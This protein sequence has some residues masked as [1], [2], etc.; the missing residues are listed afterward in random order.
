[1][2]EYDT[3]TAAAQQACRDLLLVWKP[4]PADGRFH[5]LEVEG[6]PHS[7]GGTI[8]LYADG[9]GGIATNFVT[10]EKQCFWSRSDSGLSPEELAA[11]K[12]RQ[13]QEME[14]AAQEQADRRKKAADTARAVMNSD[15]S[16][17]AALV[18]HDY[19]THKQAGATGTMRVIP[20]EALVKMIGYAPQAKGE[21]LQGDILLLPVWD[22][23]GISSIEMIDSAGR[24]SALAGGQRGGKYWATEKL[25]DNLPADI[26]IMLGEGAATVLS[27]VAA[28]PGSIGI[29]AF[30]CGNLKPVALSLRKRYPAAKLM[31]LSDLGNGERDAAEAANAAGGLLAVPTMPDGITGTDFNDLHQSAGLEEVARQLGTAAIPDKVAQKGEREAEPGIEQELRRLASMPVV[32]YERLRTTAATTLGIRAAVLD[33]LVAADRKAETSNGL[34]FDEVDPHAEPV[35]GAAL[36]NEIKATVKRFIVCKDDT[37]T[38]VT[39]WIAATW[40]VDVAQVAPIAMITAPEMRCGKSQLLS[41]MG[42]LSFRPLQA[43]GISSAAVFRTVE[44]YSPTLFIDEADAFMKDNEEMRLVLNSGHTRDSAFII[45]TEGDNHEPK[46]FSTW[47][48]K[49]IAGIS[50][51]KIAGTLTDRSLVLELRRKLDHEQVD[52]LRYCDPALFTRLSSML[53]RFAEDNRE[54]LRE[55]RPVLPGQLND[56]QQDNWEP[57]LAIATVAGGHWLDTATKAAL[58]ISGT[59]APTVSTSI[60]LLQD[61]KQA[62]EECKVDRISTVDLLAALFDDT[63]APWLTY[64]R[65]GKPMTARQLAGRLREFGVHSTTLRI[66]TGMS[67][68]YSLTQFEDA[69]SRY[70]SANVTDTSVTSDFVTDSKTLNVTD[71][72]TESLACYA[73]TDRPPLFD[74]KTRVGV[75]EVIDLSGTTFEVVL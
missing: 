49:A 31:I 10:N 12:S 69:F 48:F 36:L 65:G 29:A 4:T 15:H 16:T 38:A 27:A 21:P 2:I 72:N 41:F 42:K 7:D 8:K 56:R 17:P 18:G 44:K 33:K 63:E 62:F 24:K 14:K 59:S 28:I 58:S 5:R 37:A 40:F 25:P 19:L 39:L 51:S 52:R 47:G 67:K 34:I 26:T 57:L 74:P 64:N 55:C 30:G 6:K 1:M 50:A 71:K 75:Q 3:L 11:R 32:Q 35:N 73:V 60:E 9:E 46:R 61:I 45:R 43:A 23:D 53:A 68:G 66:G 54:A 22:H 70:L 13:K 20:H